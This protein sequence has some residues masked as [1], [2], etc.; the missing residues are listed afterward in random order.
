MLHSYDPDTPLVLLTTDRPA[1]NSSA[2]RALEALTGPDKPIRAVIGMFSPEDLEHLAE[3]AS[4][5]T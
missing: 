2:N 5:D 1:P 4:G 3:L